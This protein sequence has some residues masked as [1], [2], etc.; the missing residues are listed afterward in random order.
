MR[1]AAELT[2]ILPTY[3]EAQNIATFIP[4]IEQAFEGHAF[5]IF[6][7]DDQSPDGTAEVARGLDEQYGNIEVLTPPDRKGL[8]AALRYGTLPGPPV[9]R[10]GPQGR[11]RKQGG[12]RLG[13]LDRPR[14]GAE[15]T[16]A[17][18]L[19]LGMGPVKRQNSH[20][21]AECDTTGERTH[22]RV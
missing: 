4:E 2:I 13:G 15:L 11:G 20:K 8:G 10:D 12:G 6:V 19:G 9:R 5:R 16:L 7:V 18:R 21:Q 3:N 17:S 22:D 14:S 1:D